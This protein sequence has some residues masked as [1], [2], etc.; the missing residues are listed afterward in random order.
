MLDAKSSAEK[1]KKGDCDVEQELGGGKKTCSEKK[2]SR[3]GPGRPAALF[4]REELEG[5]GLPF[6]GGKKGKNA[7]RALPTCLDDE[8]DRQEKKHLKTL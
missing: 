2:S 1:I 5:W 8:E 3:G 7:T 6:G 4:G